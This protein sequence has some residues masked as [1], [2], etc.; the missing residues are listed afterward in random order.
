[1]EAVDKSDEKAYPN[2]AKEY[3]AKLGQTTKIRTRLNGGHGLNSV[4]HG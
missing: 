2:K 1:M 4:A 3:M